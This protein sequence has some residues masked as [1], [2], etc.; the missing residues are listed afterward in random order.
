MLKLEEFLDSLQDFAK[1]TKLNAKSVILNEGGI[2]SKTQIGIISIACA[3]A[4]KNKD[5]ISMIEGYFKDQISEKEFDAAK[6]AAIIMGMNNIYYRFI[7]M[8]SEKSYSSMPAG[9]RMNVISSHGIDKIDFEL[10]SIAVSAINGCGMC[11]DSHEKTLKTHGVSAEKVQYSVKIASV[12]NSLS[13]C[14]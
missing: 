5:L 13:F 8:A 14:F 7:H 4:T 2:L 9:L 12:M 3:V 10:A 1:D 11:I 6:S